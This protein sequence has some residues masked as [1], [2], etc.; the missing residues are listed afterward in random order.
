MNA[1][2][3]DLR[4]EILAF[5]L[6][7][8]CTGCDRIGAALCPSCRCALRAAPV[9]VRTPAGQSVRAA[10]PFTGVSARCIRALKGDGQTR[11]AAPL[12]LALAAVI[13]VV[14]LDGIVPIPTSRAAFRARGYRVPEVL[15]RASGVSPLRLLRHVGPHRDQRSAGVEE[16]ARNVRGSMAARPARAARVLLMD[17]V[18]TTGATLDE[19][20]RVLRQAGVEVVGAIALAATPRRDRFPADSAVTHPRHGGSRP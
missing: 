6:A 9:T 12:S 18:V 15:L 19:G 5:L 20:C 1:R 16:R 17:D 13:D 14:G 2:L 7:A 11:L 10:L 4:D 8:S 3:T